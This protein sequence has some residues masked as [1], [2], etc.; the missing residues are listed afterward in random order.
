MVKEGSL[1]TQFKGKEGARGTMRN[2]NNVLISLRKHSKEKNTLIK[3]YTEIYTIA[4]YFYRRTKI[5]MRIV[6]I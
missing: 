1:F 2:P 5:Y 3:D 6:E 4:I